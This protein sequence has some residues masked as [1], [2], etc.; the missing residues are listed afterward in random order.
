MLYFDNLV[1]DIDVTVGVSFMKYA[2]A[3]LCYEWL[4]NVLLLN[5]S[6]QDFKSFVPV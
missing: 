2:K 4:L 3:L 5:H 6:N 1:I